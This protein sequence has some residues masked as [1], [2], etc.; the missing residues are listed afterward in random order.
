MSR[1]FVVPGP[2]QGKARARTVRNPHTGRVQSY[3][4]PKTARYEELV[5]T[6]YREQCGGERIDTGPLT[7]SIRAVYPIPASVSKKARRQMQE[8][9]QLPT[10][11]PDADNIAKVICDALNGIAYADDKQICRLTVVKRY[12]EETRAPSV[13]ITIQEEPT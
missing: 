7:I 9:I 6:C 3:T 13:Y 1:S 11:K 10:K 5:R 12:A 4:P 8:G 2:P